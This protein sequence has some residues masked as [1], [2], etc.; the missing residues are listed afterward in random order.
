MLRNH[1]PRPLTTLGYVIECQGV[2]LRAQLRSVATLVRVTGRI[3][4]TNRDLVS[5]H[6]RRFT[7]IQG[8]L[9]LDLLDSDGFDAALLRD[10][11][12][13]IDRNGA[14][15]GTD[16]TLVVGPALRLALP[17]RDGVEVV[18]SVT[19]GLRGVAERLSVRRAFLLKS[20][21]TPRAVAPITSS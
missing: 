19:E 18:A 11:I 13:A 6:L 10:L 8:P 4:P 12:D 21:T 16:V 14:S 17:A 7:L 15:A 1:R 9:V 20:V 3:D 5:A 2:H